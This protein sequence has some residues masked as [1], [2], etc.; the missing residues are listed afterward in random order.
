MND[1]QTHGRSRLSKGIQ[2]RGFHAIGSV[3]KVP[4]ET[5]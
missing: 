2:D 3:I 1:I 4:N 5:P